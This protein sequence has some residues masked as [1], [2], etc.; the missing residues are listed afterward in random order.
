MQ[1]ILHIKSKTFSK[2]FSL[3]ELVVIIVLIGIFTTMALTRTSTGMTTIREK[4]AIDQITNDIDLARSMA[5][6]R[7]ETIT[8]KFNIEEESYSV[9][10]DSGIITDFP[11]SEN[12]IISLDNSNLRNLD[13]KEV[14]FGG[15]SDLQFLPLGDTVSG[16]TIT[17]NTKTI[18]V[19]AV[20]GKWIVG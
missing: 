6:A 11:N 5:F 3:I 8:I 10:D 13:I 7:N 2:G 16:G 1:K 19:T 20:T 4:I 9:H 18:T 12:G 17:L 15:S 14:N